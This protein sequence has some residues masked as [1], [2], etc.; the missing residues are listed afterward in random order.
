MKILICFLISSTL[1]AQNAQD[2]LIKSDRSRSLSGDNK[3]ELRVENY[4]NEQLDSAE[5]M[6]VFNQGKNKSLV[7]LEDRKGQ[8][9]LTVDENMWIYFPRTRKPMRIT[10]FQRLLGQASN[11]D[12]ARLSYAEDYTATLLK[13]D[14]INDRPCYLLELT[15]KSKASTYRKIHYWITKKNYLPLKADYFMISGKHFKTAYF[16]DYQK[17]NGKTLIGAM[18]FFKVDQPGNVTIMHFESFTE[19]SLPDKYYS[20]N[21]LRNVKL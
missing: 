6:L 21:Y 4:K 11:G 5:K 9:V 12:I 14:T 17:I 7:K 19:K 13:E 8:L 10:A 3:I 16:E 2:I 20:K 15:A 1:F 18:R